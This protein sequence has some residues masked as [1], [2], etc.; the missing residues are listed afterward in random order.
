MSHTYV[1]LLLSF[2]LLVLVRFY[3][4]LVININTNKM[5]N[6]FEKDEKEFKI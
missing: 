2:L 1:R 3:L 5:A 4:P 6:K